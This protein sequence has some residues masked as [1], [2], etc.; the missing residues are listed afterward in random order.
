MVFAESAGTFPPMGALSPFGGCCPFF[1]GG[2]EVFN[3]NKEVFL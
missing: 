1:G 3:S 2:T